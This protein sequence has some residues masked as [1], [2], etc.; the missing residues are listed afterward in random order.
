MDDH[1]RIIQ[2]I[3]NRVLSPVYLLF[4]EEPYFIDAI[5]KVVEDEVLDAGEK[6]FNQ[7]VL[8][9][10]DTDIQQLLGTVKRFP[11]MASHLV[12]ILKEAQMMKN[13]EP[14]T[15]YFEN[16][17][18]STILVICHKYKKIDK[19][20]VLYK[21]A[22]KSGVAFESVKLKD[23][24]LPGWIHKYVREHGYVINEKN[25]F[26][27]SEHLGND[28]SKISNELEKVFISLAPGSEI[29]TAIIEHSIGISRDY[30]IFELQKALGDKDTTKATRIMLYFSNN[31]K[32]YPL[33]FIISI[34]YSYFSKILKLHF[35]ESRDKQVIASQLGI[36][37]FFVP[38][39]QKATKNYT[40][41]KIA[42]IIEHLRTCDLRSKGVENTST[43]HSELLKELVFKIM[44]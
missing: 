23:F 29:T 24:Q 13:L 36:H 11:M 41:Q 8:Y 32:E 37:P 34:L 16:P 35:T 15:S 40:V 44:H 38:E 12:V 30:N 17:M 26:L 10:Y 5:S 21:S 33:I 42:K 18:P 31:M 27:I 43:S 25:C 9:G 14:L 7:I 19:R 22:Q 6:E 39:Y 20:K 4:G 28:L 1:N 2:Q 3:R